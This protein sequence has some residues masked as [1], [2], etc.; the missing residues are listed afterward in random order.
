MSSLSAAW[1]LGSSDCARDVYKGET[2]MRIENMATHEEW[3]TVVL[4][5]TRKEA[6]ELRDSLT[7]LLN[8]HVGRHEH[9][10]DAAFAREI[11]VVL[12]D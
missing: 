2:L 7:I 4:H 1:P 3:K 10:S 9:V 5:L 8:D 6:A 11:S 12:V